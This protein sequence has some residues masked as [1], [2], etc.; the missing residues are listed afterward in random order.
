MARVP[1]PASRYWCFG[2]VTAMALAWD[3]GSK[4]WVFS[5]LGY[6]KRSSDWSWS[7]D[8]LWG[9]VTVRLTTLLNQGALFGMG[10]GMGW[11][12]AALSVPA[13]AGILYWLF[14]RGEAQSRWLTVTL[15]LILAGALG[16]LYDRLY[17]HRCVDA[18][19]NAL[20]GVRD[21]LDF[22]IPMVLYSRAT[23]WELR[24]EWPWPIFNF[25]DTYLVAGAIF[26]T[27]HSL[28][29]HHKAPSDVPESP[30]KS[31]APV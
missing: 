2:I 5:E 9:R 20:P 19:G 27:L 31:P 26:L 25:A 1:V 10:Q 21:F 8:F 29:T 28:F 22:T 6:P 7:A 15:A 13:V 12:F 24:R 14:V 3:L 18:A 17:F 11:L 4:A 23:G 16:N 30:Q